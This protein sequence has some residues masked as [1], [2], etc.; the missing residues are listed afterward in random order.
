VAFDHASG[1]SADGG[2]LLASDSGTGGKLEVL[3]STIAGDTAGAN[4]G[5]V[6]IEGTAN[7]LA[8][9][10]LF[11]TLD[12]DL[13]GNQGGGIY[14][15][16]TAAGKLQL[17]NTI[18]ADDSASS[19]ANGPDIFSAGAIADLV[20]QPGSQTIGHNIIGTTTGYTG[21]TNGTAGDQLGTDPKL[22]PIANNGGPTLTN[23]LQANSPAVD[24]GTSPSDV[25][26]ITTTDQRGVTRPDGGN[27]NPDVGAFESNLG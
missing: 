8:V 16:E 9:D 23:S 22:N 5:G 15:A 1:S 26:A 6:A 13:A 24:A 12:S 20:L 14:N 2:G 4:G 19:A 17:G 7:T 27:D 3:N 11:A 25:T 21:L 10:F 18:V